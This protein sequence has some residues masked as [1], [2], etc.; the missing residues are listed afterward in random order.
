MNIIGWR[1]DG[2][3]LSPVSVLT[4]EEFSFLVSYSERTRIETN[5]QTGELPTDQERW[6]KENLISIGESAIAAFKHTN[7]LGEEV[8]RHIAEKEK[9][10]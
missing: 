7:R 9:Q 5:L 10:S 6:R 8:T 3:N 1:K 4:P 2:F